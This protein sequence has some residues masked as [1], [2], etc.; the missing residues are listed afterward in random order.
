MLNRP[1]FSFMTLMD[2]ANRYEEGYLYVPWLL[3]GT[4]FMCFGSYLSSAY[5]VSKRSVNSFV[6]SLIAAVINI[7]LNFLLIPKWGIQGASFS[8]MLS[9]AACFLVRLIDTRRYVHFPVSFGKALLNAFLLAGMSLLAVLEPPYLYVYQTA[10]CLVVV[11][12]NFKAV[13]RT[14]LK[15][16]P[17]RFHKKS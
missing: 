7:A 17:A 5:A 8:T 12:L 14:A 11:L 15:L 2:S 3:L 10:L 9:Y 16:L 1:V 13:L 4:L 6:T